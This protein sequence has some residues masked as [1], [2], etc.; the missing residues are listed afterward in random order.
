[1]NS[2]EILAWLRE[3]NPEILADLW[4]RADDQ[5]RSTVGDAVHIRGLI[6]FAITVDCERIDSRLCATG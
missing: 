3:E 1:M 6:E 5:R 2:N 4:R